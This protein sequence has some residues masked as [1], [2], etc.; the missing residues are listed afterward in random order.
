MKQKAFSLHRKNRYDMVHCRS[1]V[2][3]D[4]GLAMKKKFGIKF[5][6]DMRGFWADE[7]KD[8]GAWNQDNYLYRKIYNYY[9][10][11]EAEYLKHADYIISLTEAGKVEMESWQTFNHNVPVEVIP[12]CADI[13]HF[14]LTDAQ[15]KRKSRELLGIEQDRLIVGYLGSLGSWYMLDEMLQLFRHIKNKYA[16][17]L[18]LF[19]THSN[20]DLVLNKLDKY[21]LTKDD[22]RIM[23]ARRSEVPVFI[24]SCDISISFIKAV[25]SKKSSSPTKLGEILAMGIPVICNKGVGD[26][27]II[28]NDCNAGILIDDFSEKTFNRVA[29]SIPEML[30]L[31]AAAIR[32]K[33]SEW[34]SLEKGVGLY[35]R[36]YEK[37]LG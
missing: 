6:F 23:E 22:V 27:E 15:Q 33:S 9:K 19:V 24:K 7:K 5:F 10:G 37:V 29:D 12:C 2:A 25:F 30:R 35:L 18:F 31:D 4:I 26:V 16:N 21:D 13:D 20:P 14:S 36:S 1:Y 8:G 11:K 34:F 32:K 17:A 3:S 28:I